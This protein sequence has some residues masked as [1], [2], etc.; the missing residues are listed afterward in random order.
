MKLKLHFKT[1]ASFST[2]NFRTSSR[3]G[4]FSKSLLIKTYLILNT[5]EVLTLKDPIGP[6][7]NKRI[8]VYAGFIF[9]FNFNAFLSGVFTVSSLVGVEVQFFF[10]PYSLKHLYLR[11]IECGDS[12]F[13]VKRVFKCIWR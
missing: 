7:F 3:G 10:K 1:S 4:N 9:Y 6:P 13:W 8:C 2:D 11:E 5:W 12:V